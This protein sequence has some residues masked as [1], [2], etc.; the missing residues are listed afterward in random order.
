MTKKVASVLEKLD[1]REASDAFLRNTLV[2][3]L[4]EAHEEKER[5]LEEKRRLNGT[6]VYTNSIFLRSTPAQLITGQTT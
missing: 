2:D 3:L 5:E 6:N 4:N 1:K